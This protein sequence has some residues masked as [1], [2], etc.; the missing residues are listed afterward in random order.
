MPVE[1][2]INRA[3]VSHIVRPLGVLV[4]RGGLALPLDQRD[5]S[6]VLRIQSYA[7]ALPSPNVGRRD[8]HIAG[9][10]SIAGLYV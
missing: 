4:Q 3:A 9:L 1:R 2:S 7:I 10:P 8:T 6:M 5:P